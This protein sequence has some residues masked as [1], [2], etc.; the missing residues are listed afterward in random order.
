[1]TKGKKKKN[2]ERESFNVLKVFNVT[3]GIYRFCYVFFVDETD[4]KGDF[5]PNFYRN[6]FSLRKT[7]SKPFLVN[8]SDGNEDG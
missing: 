3:R 5:W 1:M 8:K 7:S 6:W 2:G 4:G